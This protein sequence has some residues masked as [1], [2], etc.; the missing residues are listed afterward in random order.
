[1][2]RTIEINALTR[3]GIEVVCDLY[4]RAGRDIAPF[5]T[6]AVSALP[7]TILHDLAVRDALISLTRLLQPIIPV[8]WFTMSTR[9]LIQ[10]GHTT[11]AQAP[12]LILVAGERK[13]PLLVEV[14]LGTESVTGPAAN[15]WQTKYARY[16]DYLKRDY[17]NDPLFEGCGKP[18]VVVLATGARRTRNLAEAIAGWGGQRAW[19]CASLESLSPLTYQPPGRVWAV[20]TAD[21]PLSLTEA[22]GLSARL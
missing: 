7:E 3:E 18:L 1:M 6:G 14:D 16:A 12:D 4:A 8:H 20:P 21:E 13:V 15:S 11:M 2:L 10:H 9:G 17:G 5:S 22:L 19:W